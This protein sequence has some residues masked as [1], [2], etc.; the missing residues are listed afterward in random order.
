MVV[1]F[2]ERMVVDPETSIIIVRYGNNNYTTLIE[3]IRAT[4]DILP[5]FTWGISMIGM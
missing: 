3:V 2:Y 4:L 5:G 1:D